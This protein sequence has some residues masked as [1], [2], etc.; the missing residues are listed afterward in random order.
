MRRKFSRRDL[1]GSGFNSRSQ[2]DQLSILPFRVRPPGAVEERLFLALCTACDDC[3]VACPKNAIHTLADHVEPGSG[4]P[5]MVLEERA[6][7]LCEEFPCI[8]SCTEGALVQT[9]GMRSWFFGHALI[10]PGRCL[11]YLG[12]ECG[13]CG[14]RCPP[15]AENA[16]K[17]IADLPAIDTDL[18]IGCGICLESCP[19]T[20]KA[21]ELTIDPLEIGPILDMEVV[22]MA[23]SSE[24][25]P[26]SGR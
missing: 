6:C 21:I 12:P 20:P 23:V 7:H 14:G 24:D 25:R 3:V 11:P 17:I 2:R 15:G 18:C 5:V 4:T 19:V 22:D 9:K 13:A 8:L 16:L 1:V 10:D 26:K